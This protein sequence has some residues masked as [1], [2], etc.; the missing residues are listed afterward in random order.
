MASDGLADMLEQQQPS[1][2]ILELATHIASEHDGVDYWML[3]CFDCQLGR[4]LDAYLFRLPTWC[5]E[6]FQPS[7]IIALMKVHLATIERIARKKLAETTPSGGEACKK[8]MQHYAED[9]GGEPQ[10]SWPAEWKRQ[11]KPRGAVLS[12]S[13]S[14]VISDNE[15]GWP[16]WVNMMHLE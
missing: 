11:R 16:G 15:M 6:N 7:G 3:T 10:S 9:H 12:E 1:G 4:L 8:K 14:L 5:C 2:E 13:C